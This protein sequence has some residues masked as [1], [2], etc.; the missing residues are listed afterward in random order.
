MH[1]DAE[2]IVVAGSTITALALVR[3]AHALSIDCTLLDTTAGIATRSQLATTQV[4]R[5]AN[6]SE[7]VE[8]LLLLGRERPSVLVADSDAWLRRLIPFRATIDDVYRSVLHPRNEV[9]ELCLNKTAFLTW[10]SKEGLPAARLFSRDEVEHLDYATTP[11]IVRPELTLHGQGKQLPKAAEIRNRI[12]MRMLLDAYAREGVTPCIAQSLITCRTRQFSIGVARN[13]RGEIQ[14]FVGEKLR[15]DARRCSGGTLV[16]ASPHRA[17]AELAEQAI[18]RLDYFGIAE[19]EVFL[20]EESGQL[21]LVEVN[22]RPWVQYELARQS[23]YDHLR[24][25]LEPNS[26]KDHARRRPNRRWLHFWDDL[27]VCFRRRTGVV[28]MREIGLLDYLKSI[29]TANV[30]AIWSW[31]DPGPTLYDFRSRIRSFLKNRRSL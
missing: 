19:V 25:L 27:Y 4:F 13:E 1:L 16:V 28:A 8:R 11:A 5:G 15:P 22:P 14:L 18:S 17:A 26:P 23:G 24:F 3:A 29:A 7:I 10:C 20:Q 6:D 30:S 21:F 12:E 31:R 9:L 2:H